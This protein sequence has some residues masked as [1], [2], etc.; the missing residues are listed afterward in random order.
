MRN[1]TA[2]VKDFLSHIPEETNNVWQFSETP[3]FGQVRYE[4]MHF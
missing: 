2:K 1:E 3:I 4:I